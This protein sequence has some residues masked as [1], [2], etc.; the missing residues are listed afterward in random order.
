MSNVTYSF[1]APTNPT[2][3]LVPVSN[4]TIGP[5]SIQFGNGTGSA[6][7][8]VTASPAGCSGISSGY[9]VVNG[10][11]TG[12]IT[13][14]VV[15]PQILLQVMYGEAYGEA[16]AYPNGIDE[17]A[18]GVTIRN[19]LGDSTYFSGSTTYQNT[20][21]TQQFPNGAINTSI[22]TGTTPQGTQSPE[23]INA[24][25][26]FAGTT[27]VSVASAKCYFSPTSSEWQSIQAALNS[28]TTDLPTV[29]DDPG[30]YTHHEQFVYKMSISPSTIPINAGAPAFIFTQYRA[31]TAPAVIE[32][33]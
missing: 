14:V 31:Q 10:T 8:V 17:Q 24:A 25:A 33:P 11:T 13:Q 20:I 5:L 27:S 28:P 19:R 23:L 3:N 6:S 2:V 32:I 29:A 16:R 22:T 26:V 4:C 12:N 1:T 18:V 30:C 15:P 7:S 9:G 21:T